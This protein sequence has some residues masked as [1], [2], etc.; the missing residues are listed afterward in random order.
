M[1]SSTIVSDD[2]IDL[3]LR[4]RVVINGGSRRRGFATPA[5][6]AASYLTGTMIPG[7]SAS[8]AGGS[9][10]RATPWI[11]QSQTLDEHTRIM[12]EQTGMLREILSRL[13]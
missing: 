8:T 7:R 1:H 6:P 10:S 4:D 2:G 3:G 13:P 9:V 5:L 11:E 12:S